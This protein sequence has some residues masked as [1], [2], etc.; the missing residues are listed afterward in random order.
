MCWKR[1]NPNCNGNDC[2]AP[3]CRWTYGNLP[4]RGTGVVKWH[5]GQPTCIKNVEL[6]I[7]KIRTGCQYVGQRYSTRG[8]QQRILWPATSR[9][10]DYVH[11]IAAPTTDDHTQKI[12]ESEW[13]NKK[14]QTAQ[15]NVWVQAEHKQT[16]TWRT[17]HLKDCSVF[18]PGYVSFATLRWQRRG[19]WVMKTGFSTLRG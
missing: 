16:R 6:N 3:R 9:L 13:R 4:A 18:S 19:K 5:W 15:T 8:P 7:I 2:L 12:R 10:K 17:F 11:M 14:R 1:S